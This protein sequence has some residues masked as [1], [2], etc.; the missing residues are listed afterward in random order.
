[1][2]NRIL[3]G[4]TVML[5]MVMTGMEKGIAKEEPV[6][7][8]SNMR[9]P[10]MATQLSEDLARAISGY[11]KSPEREW[12]IRDLSHSY[13]WFEVEQLFWI[14]DGDTNESLLLYKEPGSKWQRLNHEKTGLPVIS[15][16]L[17]DKSSRTPSPKNSTEPFAKLMME[18]IQEPRG[19]VCSPSFLKEQS[20]VIGSFLVKG[21]AGLEDLKSVCV[22]P[23]YSE[24]DGRWNVQFNVLDVDGSIQR[25]IVGGKFS[26]FEIDKVTR[27]PIFPKGTFFY[28]NEF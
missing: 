23:T 24:S 8:E 25:W 16:I 18:W 2:R 13:K 22:S 11:F 5:S 7:S 19:Y 12:W 9:N 10:K 17:R 27:E 28:P 21:S 14:I 15:K 3:A 4:L 26:G 6:K 20:P 1:M